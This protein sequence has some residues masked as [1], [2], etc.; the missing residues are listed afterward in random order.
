MTDHLEDMLRQKAIKRRVPFTAIFELTYRCNFHCP[1]CYIRMTDAQAAPFGRMRTM[2]EWLDMARQVREAG[3]FYITLTGGECTQYPDF[4]PLYKALYQ[5]G[6]RITLMSNAADYSDEIKEA[7]RAFPPYEVT[8]TLYGG[9]SETYRRVTGD[10]QGFDKV[11]DNIHFL[12]S[13]GIPM[14]INF[15]V[16][17]ENIRDYPLI[18]AIC[19][20]LK[21]SCLLSS[22]LFVHAWDKR[23]SSVAQHILSPAERACVAC[24]K[25]E[26]VEEALA[27]AQELEKLWKPEYLPTARSEKPKPRYCNGSSC[28]SAILW[29]G[30]LQTCLSLAG[31]P[32]YKPFEIGFDAAWKQL[33]SERDARFMTSPV[34]D[35]CAFIDNCASHCAARN[36]QGTGDFYTPDPAVCKYTWFVNQYKKILAERQADVPSSN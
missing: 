23:Y 4:V 6:F 10:P 17:R 26:E 29:N 12:R 11:M 2:A 19:D 30:D 14:R 20:E 35:A 13:L 18:K 32:A 34:C 3:V 7:L 8:T 27:D 31:A 22:D 9:S 25:P 16:I 1:M 36:Y 24:R 5:M 15:T 21:L 28:S 33:Q